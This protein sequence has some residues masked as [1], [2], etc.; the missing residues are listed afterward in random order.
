MK[1]TLEQVMDYLEKEIEAICVEAQ[2]DTDLPM[3]VIGQQWDDSV[4]FYAGYFNALS[5]VKADLSMINLLR[6]SK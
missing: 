3:D 6:E 1:L 2:E 4:S 5:I